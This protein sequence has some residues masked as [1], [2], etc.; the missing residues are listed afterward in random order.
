MPK[1][2]DL[3]ALPADEDG[4]CGSGSRRRRRAGAAASGRVGGGVNEQARQHPGGEACANVIV[5]VDEGDD[6]GEARG[7]GSAGKRPKREKR[8]DA[9]PTWQGLNG[10]RCVRVRARERAVLLPVSRLRRSRARLSR[11]RVRLRKRVGRGRER[12]RWK[13]L[14]LA[15]GLKWLTRHPLGARS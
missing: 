9:P 4:G 1:A 8:A 15:R 5:I 3:T 2:I 11:A 10:A 14:H 13:P 7:Q 12:E 6:S